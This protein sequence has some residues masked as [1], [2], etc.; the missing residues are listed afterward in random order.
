MRVFDG[1]GTNNLPCFHDDARRQLVF[2]LS[3]VGCVAGP[4]AGPA[5][6]ARLPCSRQ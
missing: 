5:R 6:M 4:S 2:D 1:G 3:N